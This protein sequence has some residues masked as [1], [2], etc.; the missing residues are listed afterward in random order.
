MTFN[1]VQEMFEN[2]LP[3]NG[4]LGMFWGDVKRQ[5]VLGMFVGSAPLVVLS[6]KAKDRVPKGAV[7]D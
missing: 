1:H 2:V 6:R 7:K 4:L 5:N 3:P